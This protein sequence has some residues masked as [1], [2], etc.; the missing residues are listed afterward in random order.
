MTYL[1]SLPRDAALL[2]VFRRFPDTAAPLLDYHQALL[3]GSSPLSV[4]ER[5][6]IAAYVSGLN[7]CQYCHGVHS[8]TA[9]AFGVSDGVLSA[10]LADVD[11]APVVE[12][13][14]PMLQYAGKLT[15]SPNRVTPSDAEAVFAAGWDEQALHDAVS[16][17][18]LFN[19]MNRLVEGLGL[20]AD[21]GYFST[22]A[23]RLSGERGYLA[24]RDA[25]NRQD[26]TH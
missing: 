23:D 12:H 11:T 24:L 25:L 14:K 10:L 13:M 19:F 16:V 26:E 1:P 15:L 5:E 17:C 20:T 2:D 21:D 9:Q 4:A 7:A 18:A 8:A 3:R 22:A 6:L